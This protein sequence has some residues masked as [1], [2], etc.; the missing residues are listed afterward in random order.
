MNYKY[1]NKAKAIKELTKS[2]REFGVHESYLESI[3]EREKM[4]SF[5]IGYSIAIPHGTYEAIKKLN[6][7][8]IVIHHL[9]KPIMWDYDKVQILIGIAVK[10]EKQMQLLQNIAINSI[11]K[12]FYND[13]L[14]N[15]TLEKIEKLTKEYNE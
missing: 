7:L 1:K 12:D 13:I 10:N 14:K 2:L 8:V 15:P 6:N 11:D 9:A 5:N 3:Y 4:A